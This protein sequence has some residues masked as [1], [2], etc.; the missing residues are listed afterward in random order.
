MYVNISTLLAFYHLYVYVM[1]YFVLK[2]DVKNMKQNI[3]R[4]FMHILMNLDN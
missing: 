3:H 4:E 2:S 1:C